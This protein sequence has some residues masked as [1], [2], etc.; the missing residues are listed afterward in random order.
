MH[1]TIKSGGKVMDAYTLN[2][3]FAANES[4]YTFTTPVMIPNKPNLQISCY[5]FDG[6]KNLAA[7][8]GEG[9]NKLIEMMN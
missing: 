6:V 4:N 8:V 3:G 1:L 9:W 5:C 7:V 2:H